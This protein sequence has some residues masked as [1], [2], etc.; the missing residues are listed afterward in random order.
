MTP[1]DLPCTSVL[2]GMPCGT[3]AYTNLCQ[4]SKLV[5]YCASYYLENRC[6]DFRSPHLRFH[7]SYKRPLKEIKNVLYCIT[8]IAIMHSQSSVCSCDKAIH[9]YDVMYFEQELS[10][11]LILAFLAFIPGYSQP[12]SHAVFLIM[13]SS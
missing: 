3:Y 4:L 7:C 9:S 5:I 13:L 1:R 10:S 8:S 11:F 6:P 2:F 12:P